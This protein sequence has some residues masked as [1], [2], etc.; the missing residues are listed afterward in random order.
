MDSVRVEENIFF[1]D[2][3]EVSHRNTSDEP[4]NKYFYE[5]I[6]KILIFCFCL[7]GLWFYVPINSY[8]HVEMV[9]CYLTILFSGQS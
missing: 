2:S 1:K 7:F 4:C 3:M 8:G 6:R 5:E 9:S